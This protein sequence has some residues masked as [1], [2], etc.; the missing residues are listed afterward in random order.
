MI[1]SAPVYTEFIPEG[2][3]KD[4][5]KLGMRRHREYQEYAIVGLYSDT[6]DYPILMDERRYLESIRVGKILSLAEF[7][8]F[9]DGK[10]AE[11]TPMKTIIDEP[12]SKEPR[13]PGREIR[14]AGHHWLDD[15]NMDGQFCGRVVLQWNPGAKRWSHSGMVGTGSYVDTSYWKYVGPCPIPE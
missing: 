14:L 8:R 2:P 3:F 12:Y 1:S 5:F 13:P 4:M 7:H 15:F 6:R 10:E 9:L 11:K